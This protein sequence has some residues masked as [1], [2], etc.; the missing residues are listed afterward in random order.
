MFTRLSKL[1]ALAL[2]CVTLTV[3]FMALLDVTIV[4]VAIPS[5][6]EGLDTS[7]GNGTRVCAKL[8][9]PAVE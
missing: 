5:I 9:M 3:G 7:P 6:R 8:P 1:V 2:L 4:N